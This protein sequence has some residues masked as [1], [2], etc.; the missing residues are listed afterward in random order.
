MNKTPLLIGLFLLLSATTAGA[1]NLLDELKSAIESSQ[2]QERR[3]LSK[4]A[5]T[6]INFPN[7]IE[8]YASTTETPVEIKGMKLGMPIIEIVKNFPTCE[9]RSV[10]PDEK[11]NTPGD[12][13]GICTSKI[14]N[15]YFNKN[16]NCDAAT[17]GGKNIKQIT[18][19]FKNKKLILVNVE[20][21][22]RD[23]DSI[24]E[25]LKKKFGVKNDIIENDSEKNDI[26]SL[27]F[28][29]IE[30]NRMRRMT[31]DQLKE[32]YATTV[33]VWMNSKSQDVLTFNKRTGLASM[34][35][36]SFIDEVETIEK[37][38]KETTELT[39]PKKQSQQKSSDI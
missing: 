9:F 36:H 35:N 22:G 21:S 34:T 28:T 37:N 13:I 19:I 11:K 5:E 8:T 15:C 18:M 7:T 26:L 33:M 24:L 38:K 10:T 1:V 32:F 30:I 29:E 17:F 25:S 4:P 2:Q 12:Q 3:Q 39:Q 23:N 16:E 31:R 14:L 20:I 6:N 27:G